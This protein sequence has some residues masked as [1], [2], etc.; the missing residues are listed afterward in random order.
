MN[1]KDRGPFDQNPKKSA[2]YIYM[3]SPPPKEDKDIK[4]KQGG[5]QGDK[6][7]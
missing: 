2:P 4:I 1:R 7:K 6:K 5:E 3:I